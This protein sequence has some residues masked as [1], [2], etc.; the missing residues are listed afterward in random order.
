MVIMSE[1]LLQ[2][3]KSKGSSIFSP[4]HPTSSPLPPQIS[5]IWNLVFGR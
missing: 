1:E 4:M 3:I 5:Y 2:I